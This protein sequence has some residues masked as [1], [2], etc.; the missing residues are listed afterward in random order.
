MTAPP[1]SDPGCVEVELKFPVK[2]L[3]PVIARVESLG[4]VFSDPIYQADT[5]YAHPCRDF[6]ATDEALRLRQDDHQ[7][8]LTYKGPKLDPLSKTRYEVDMP[9]G[10]RAQARAALAEILDRLGF[11]PVAT[12]VKRRR[13]A[14]VDWEG[15]N[16]VVSCDEVEN[17]GSF[18]EL[19]IVCPLPERTEVQDQL[20]KLADALAL[21]A[22]P[23]ERRSYLELLLTAKSRP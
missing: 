7:T 6:A 17:L 9:L 2:D 22:Y 23:S 3:R 20:W 10:D 1:P 4:G 16:A 11:R 21:R 18:V 5:Y 8:Y 14:Q 15:R 13:Y 19:E 12:V